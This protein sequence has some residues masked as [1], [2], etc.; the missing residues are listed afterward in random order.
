MTE[1]KKQK[2]SEKI[3][4]YKNENGPEIG[5]TQQQV[6]CEDGLYFRDINGDGK[7]NTYKDWRKS[8]K[9][10]AKA[11]AAELSVDEKIGQ[12]FLSSWKMGIEQEDKE[13]V[14][15]MPRSIIRT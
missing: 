15:S 1:I 8:P 6:I 10:R 11:L 13:F 9:E 7:L 5:V 12:L 2:A 14:Q 3:R 4:Y